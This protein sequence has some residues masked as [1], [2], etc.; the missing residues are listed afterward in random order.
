MEENIEF[1]F[2]SVLRE[3]GRDENT[4]DPIIKM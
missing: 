3:Y 2:K 4:A 1:V